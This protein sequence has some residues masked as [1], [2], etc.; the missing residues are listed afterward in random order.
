V[1]R[2]RRE[3]FGRGFVHAYTRGNNRSPVFF[4]EFDYVAW[5][6][7]LE[8]TVK[9]FGWA[10]H[11]YCLMPNHY[12]LLLESSQNRISAGMR[13]LNGSFAQRINVRYDRTGHLFEGPY[14]EE[15]VTDHPYL[16]ELTRYLPLNPVRARLCDRPEEWQWSSYRATAGLERRPEFLTVSFVRS[17]FGR[18]EIGVARYR[19][20]VSEGAVRAS[21]TSRDLVPRRGGFGQ[22]R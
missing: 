16:L 9:R 15:L 21:K 1:G 20:F 13:H 14:H 18:G 4:D 2:R 3:E 12:H 11:A 5:L 17:L 7:I 22:F 10:C 8:R 19:G 6:R